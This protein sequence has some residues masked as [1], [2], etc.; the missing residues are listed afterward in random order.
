MSHLFRLRFP[1]VEV[2]QWADRYQYADDAEVERIGEHAGPGQRG[3]GRARRI[4]GAAR[5][6]ST[7][8]DYSPSAA[9][10]ARRAASAAIWLPPVDLRNCW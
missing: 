4:R 10:W 8:A 2:G 3:R 6:D 9:S 7:A 1:P 5:A